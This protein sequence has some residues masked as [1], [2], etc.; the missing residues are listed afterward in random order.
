[1]ADEQVQDPRYTQLQNEYQSEL[2]ESTGLYSARGF[3]RSTANEAAIAQIGKEYQARVSTLGAIIFNEQRLKT[4]KTVEEAKAVLNALSNL[5]NTYSQQSQEA[6]QRRSDL[7]KA[8]NDLNAQNQNNLKNLWSDGKRKGAYI[9]KKAV[10]T[11]N[12]KVQ[13]PKDTVTQKAFT[14]KPVAQIAPKSK[15]FSKSLIP[16]RKIFHI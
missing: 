8:G 12:N 4:V 16:H 11:M 1:M 10:V 15:M 6:G 7:L 9:V 14:P 3:G 2:Q 13:S 5:Y